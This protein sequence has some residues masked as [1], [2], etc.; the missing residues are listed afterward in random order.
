MLKYID[1]LIQFVFILYLFI[2]IAYIQTYKNYLFYIYLF[3][4]L[5]IHLLIKHS[6]MNEWMNEWINELMNELIN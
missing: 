1:K 6:W 3:I 2:N 4:Y 5:Y